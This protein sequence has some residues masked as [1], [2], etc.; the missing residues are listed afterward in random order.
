MYNRKFNVKRDFSKINEL[1]NK[2]FP[3]VRKIKNDK[4]AKFL[5]SYLWEL[6]NNQFKK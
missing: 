6:F 1:E 2:V 5:E 4:D 3:I